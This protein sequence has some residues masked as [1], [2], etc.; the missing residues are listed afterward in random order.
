M[1]Q[2]TTDHSAA[3]NAAAA[4]PLLGLFLLMPPMVTLFAHGA[5]VGG[6]PLIIIYIFSVWVGL[7]AGAGLLARHLRPQPTPEAS[8][9]AAPTSTSALPH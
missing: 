7:I 1:D 5:G 9:A 2:P 6:V 3:A 4:L 8:A